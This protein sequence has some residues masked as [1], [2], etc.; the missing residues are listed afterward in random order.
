MSPADIARLAS[1]PTERA[2]VLLRNQHP[3]T[4]AA[5]GRATVRAIRRLGP[6]IEGTGAMQMHF[7]PEKAT[8]PPPRA[9]V[10]RSLQDRALG[11]E[12]T[13]AQ[14]Q[15]DSLF[16][17]ACPSIFRERATRAIWDSKC[18]CRGATR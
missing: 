2:I 16:V 15:D 6:L 8:A 14:K 1:H 7:V 5:A 12:A 13:P 18:G 10:L 11:R 4:P 17:L 3:E 9:S